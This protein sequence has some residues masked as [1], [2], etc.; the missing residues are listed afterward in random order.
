MSNG[1]FFRN[2]WGNRDTFTS[3][4]TIAMFARLPNY[5]PKGGERGKVTIMRG[6]GGS[7]FHFSKMRQWRKWKNIYSFMKNPILSVIEI[8]LTMHNVFFFFNFFIILFFIVGG[9]WVLIG[10]G[11][12]GILELAP[13][14][15]DWFD[16]RWP[17]S[18]WHVR[19]CVLHRLQRDLFSVTWGQT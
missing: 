18:R 11:R 16:S 9:G 3:E 7:R 10:E 12:V 8:I 15:L 19:R 14:F 1:K 6:P 13:L 4:V 2:N 5:V 17:L